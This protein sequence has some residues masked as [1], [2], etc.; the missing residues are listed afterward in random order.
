MSKFVD[1]LQRASRSSATTIGFHPSIAES[2]GPAVLLITG[3]S[4]TQVKE[5]KIVAEANA[6]AGL[7]LSDEPSGKAVRQMVE[8]VGDVPLGVLV[9]GM[10]EQKMN[11]LADSGCDF[12]VIDVEAAAT[13]L[14]EE[15][16]GKFL[17]IELSL[18]QGLVRAIN[19]LEVDGVFVGV[20]GGDSMITV[21]RL[22]IYRRF[23]ELLEKPVIAA[24]PASVTK[25][26]LKSLWQTG[27]YG[28]VT[29]STQSAAALT[30]VRKMISDLPRGPRGRRAKAGVA[31]PHYDVDVAGAGEEDEEQENI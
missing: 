20:P 15:K 17:A 30:E 5:A 29:S 18:D 26:E 1:K 28:V 31:L 14:H 6:D 27:I 25:G 3:L 16:L 12:L 13:V 9:R 21:E 10:N 22:L 4:G 24:L 23:V 8:A 7:L 2:K 11:E 19:S